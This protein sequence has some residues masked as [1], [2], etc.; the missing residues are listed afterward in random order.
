VPVNPVGDG[1]W[2]F[3]IEIWNDDSPREY[4]A[5]FTNPG[6]NIANITLA[7]IPCFGN[8][9]IFVGFD[10]IPTTTN[11]F[12]S[13]PWDSTAALQQLTVNWL[14]NDTIYFL[15][16]GDMTF[17]GN[18]SASFQFVVWST[19]NTAF[20]FYND[21]PQVS[22][23]AVTATLATGGASATIKWTKTSNSADNYTV[24]YSGINSKNFNSATTGQYTLTGCSVQ[25]SMTP[26][27]KN[28]SLKDN[29]DGTI[30][31]SFTDLNPKDILPV[32]VVV[33]RTHGT[34]VAYATEFINSSSTITG[35]TLLLSILV[36]F[37]LTF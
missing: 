13:K 28:I 21:Y 8:T 31:A 18:L 15:F 5:S 24:Y 23:D 6:P 36:A 14:L 11:Y 29:G 20:S 17:P 25:K 7:F 34:T 3:D 35:L 22:N 4:L 12:I 16:V 19:A 27:T 1:E 30:T 32:T 26:F 10:E 37:A 2:F 9:D 33:S